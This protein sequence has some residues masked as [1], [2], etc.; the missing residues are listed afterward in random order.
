M[1]RFLCLYLPR[2]PLQ[3]LLSENSG[4]QKNDGPL[5]LFDR[6]AH[7][8]RI[9][10][11]SDDAEKCG[12]GPGMLMADATALAHDLQLHEIDRRAD[13]AA[14]EAL[15][16]WAGQFSPLVGLENTPPGEHPEALLLDITGC[17]QV[18]GGEQPLMRQAAQRLSRRHFSV[19]AAIAP[20]LGAAWALAHFGENPRAIV[21]NSK[22]SDLAANG[23]ETERGRTGEGA[24]S[25]SISLSAPRDNPL[26]PGEGRHERSECGVR[27]DAPIA[28][29][30]KKCDQPSVSP[31]PPFSP[32]PFLSLLPLHALRL[33]A[34]ALAWL[35]K[36]GVRNIGDLIRQP[37]SSL[38]SR[39]GAEVL[40]RLDQALGHAAETLPLLRPPPEFYAAMAFEYPIRNTDL[41]LAV[42]EKLLERLCGDMRTRGRGARELECW[43]Y[44]E[45]SAPEALDVTLHK[46]SATPRHLLQLL[47]T[48]FEDFFSPLNGKQR[49]EG[50]KQKAES[51]RELSELTV[52]AD[53]GVCAVA[54]R[55]NSSEALET[56]QLALFHQALRAPAS[57]ALTLDRLSTRLG[58]QTVWRVELCDDAQPEHAYKLVEQ[59]DAAALALAPPRIAAPARPL[60]LLPQPQP[61][62]VDWPDQSRQPRR[63]HWR[64]ESL[65]VIAA[66]GPERIETGWWRQT[67]AERDYYMVDCENGA[68]YWIFKELVEGTWFLHGMDG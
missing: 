37:R 22:E 19:R 32:S 26:P 47:K 60:C 14:L 23:R 27:A 50:G 24:I 41:L 30:T 5:A 13:R 2:W 7:G 49:T 25:A 8:P 63:I 43:L 34:D 59:A 12:V 67:R 61:L 6:T 66:W 53:D 54:L 35:R 11:C 21:D 10:V 46:A 42:A 18:F 15:A 4:V 1:R 20:T 38:P 3:R 29:E 51:G 64:G 57:L 44:H 55:V 48:R 58:P 17:A 40:L 16:L 31:L 9:A 56:E 39:F 36:L 68:R 33:T 65:N 62:D 45:A 28:I 52:D